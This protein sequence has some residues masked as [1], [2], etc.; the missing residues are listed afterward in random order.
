MLMIIKQGI[1]ESYREAIIHWGYP[2]FKDLV[3]KQM[4]KDII[5]RQTNWDISLMLVNKDDEDDVLGIYLLG[6]MQLSESVNSDMFDKLNGVEGVLL[7]IDESIRSEG[8][9]SKLKD[10]TRTLG[11]DYI[12][13]QQYATLNNL[14]DWLKRRVLIAQSEEVNIT[15]EFFKK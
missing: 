15:A 12:W 3:G 5:K 2:Y 8:W 14:D 1:S 4:F 9:G 6:N 10:H 13:G 7:L 11:F